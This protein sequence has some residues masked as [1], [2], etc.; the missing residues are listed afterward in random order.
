[1]IVNDIHDDL[2][3]P[4]GAFGDQFFVQSIGT[5]TRIHPVEIRRS[6]T[7]IRLLGQIIFKHRIQPQGRD[8]QTL[9]IIQVLEQPFQIPPVP[10]LINAPIHLLLPHSGNT[11]VAGIPVRKTIRHHQINQIRSAPTSPL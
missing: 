6:I 1:M 3:A 7:V 2:D 9:D 11:I 5:Q 8:T 4:L 10:G